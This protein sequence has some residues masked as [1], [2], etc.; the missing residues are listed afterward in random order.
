MGN[1]TIQYI[2]TVLTPGGPVISLNTNL[3]AASQLD[4]VA[5]GFNTAVACIVSNRWSHT[6]TCDDCTAVFVHL[7]IN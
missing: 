6:Q 1:N 5:A 4:R 3:V 7:Q 2:E